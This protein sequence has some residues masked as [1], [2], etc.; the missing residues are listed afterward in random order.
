[1]YLLKQLL[2]YQRILVTHHRVARTVSA[3]KSTN[4]LFVLASQRTLEVHQDVD[5]NAL[6]VQ[7]VPKTKLA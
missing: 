4:K 2:K 5:P 7:N 6:S 3:E 1:M